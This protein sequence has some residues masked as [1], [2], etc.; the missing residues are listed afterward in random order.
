MTNAFYEFQLGFAAVY[1]VQGAIS[2]LLPSTDYLLR[3]DRLLELFIEG[4]PI[5]KEDFI[6]LKMY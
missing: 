6:P 1:P 3:V 4:E 2:P 5:N